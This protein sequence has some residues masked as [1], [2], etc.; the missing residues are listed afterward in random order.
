MQHAWTQ[1]GLS[2]VLAMQ[3]GRAMACF[4]AR[5]TNARSHCTVVTSTRNALTQQ[6]RLRVRAMRAGPEMA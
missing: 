5:L 1:L 3:A 2:A 4:A 6:A